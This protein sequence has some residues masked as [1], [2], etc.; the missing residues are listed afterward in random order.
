MG[1]HMSDDKYPVGETVVS[2]QIV[3]EI[4]MTLST[5]GKGT[6]FWSV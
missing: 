6:I 5:S 4:I 1:L 3:L 2:S